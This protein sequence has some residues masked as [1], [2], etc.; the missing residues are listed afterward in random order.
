MKLIIAGGR[1]FNNPEIFI[2][3]MEELIKKLDINLDN[4]EIV[5][6][7]AVGADKMGEEWA[8]IN[9]IPIKYF[10][11]KWV[12][13][14]KSAGYRRN[15]QMADYADVLLAFWDGKSKGTKHMIDLSVGH[16]LLSFTE[17]Y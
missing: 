5:S 4:L 13:Y 10:P 2:N 3:A 14:G 9:S 15:A 16:K 11:A 7:T 8:L 6:G 12:T 17:S 1:D